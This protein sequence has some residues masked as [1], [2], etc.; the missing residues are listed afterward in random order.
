MR[1]LLWI[2]LAVA[3][4]GC[5]SDG[6]YTDDS[7]TSDRCESDAHYWN[8]VELVCEDPQIDVEDSEQIGTDSKSPTM[9][10]PPT[11]NHPACYYEDMDTLP[12]GVE[13]A[14]EVHL[15]EVAPDSNKCYSRLDLIDEIYQE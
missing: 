10:C 5:G 7:F 6:N 2:G 14:P 15:C 12:E 4:L 11:V 13:Y 9:R 3:S 8:G 1:N